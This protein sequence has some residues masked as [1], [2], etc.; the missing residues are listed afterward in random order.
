[1]ALG[2]P[3]FL[4]IGMRLEGESLEFTTGSSLDTRDLVK[5]FL[6]IFRAWKSGLL[7]ARYALARLS[8]SREV[9]MFA[10]PWRGDYT[11][12]SHCVL[13]VVFGQLYS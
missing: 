1:V 6:S 7:L 2:E 8:S 3:V 12:I 5:T 9:Y 13:L 10:S 4:G 11:R